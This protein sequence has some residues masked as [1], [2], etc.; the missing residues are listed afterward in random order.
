MLKFLRENFKITNDCIILATPMVIFFISIQWFI[1][2]FQNILSLPANNIAFYLTLW[3][4]ISGCFAG[5]FYMTKKT[6]QFSKKTFLYDTDRS[7]AL[8]KL[9]L[10]LFKGVGKFFVSF[11]IMVAVCFCFKLLKYGLL[12]SLFKLPYKLDISQVSI[13]SIAIVLIF[14]YF[15]IYWI[16]EIVYNYT[17]AFKAMINSVKMTILSFKNTFPLYIFMVLIGI[18][19]RIIIFMAEDNPFTYFLLIILTYYYLLY[20]ILIIFRDYERNYVT[21]N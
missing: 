15:F 13:I 21:K 16:P 6:L 9:F 4:W 3:I 14:W 19:L 7:T 1:Q 10:C 17:N 12:L 8:T 20:F 2:T 5:W 18:L 11:L